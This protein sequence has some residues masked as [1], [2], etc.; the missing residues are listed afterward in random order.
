[1][2]GTIILTGANSS[3]GIPAA[4]HLL[5]AY[6][7][8]NAIFT[9][10]DASSSD[11][12]TARLR[13]TI[14]RFPNAKATV[15][16]LDL[17]NL[18][19]VHAF[20]D[21]II[22]DISTGKYPPLAAIIA[23]TYYWN[24][25]SDPEIT[26]DGFD[27]TIEVA[28]IAHSAP[29]S[30]TVGQLWGERPCKN[31]M[32][33][34]PPVIPS[35]LDELIKPVADAD[36][37]GRGYQRYATAKLAVTTWLYPLNRYLQNDASLSRISAVAINPGNLVDS[38]ALTSNTPASLH[39]MQRFVFKPLLP[40]LKMSMGPTLRTAQPAGIDVVELAVNPRFADK[41]GFFNVV[42]GRSELAG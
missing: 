19:A 14:S 20:A 21:R 29:H 41:R 15:D 32:E 11:A 40:L 36:K 39:R 16:A 26:S 35:D 42:A 12:N 33:K 30:A 2:A 13:E 23:N 31:S 8:Y 4:E 17:S 38:R 1:M 25:V 6:P 27:K 18:S 10:R 37:Q 7:A 22:S 24:L 3:L 28:H 9:V 34:Y 5:S